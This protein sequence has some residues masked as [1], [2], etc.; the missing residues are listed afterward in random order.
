MRGPAPVPPPPPP[1]SSS[2]T[3]EEVTVD[4]TPAPAF[5]THPDQVNLRDQLTETSFMSETGTMG[6]V[7]LVLDDLLDEVARGHSRGT[8]FT[9]TTTT[10]TVY[11]DEDGEEEQDTDCGDSDGDGDMTVDL[12]EELR[13]QGDDTEEE[14]AALRRGGSPSPSLSG[15]T[16]DEPGVKATVVDDMDMSPSP[17][18]I[19]EAT[20]IDVE[21]GESLGDGGGEDVDADN[22]DALA[23]EEMAD[24]DAGRGVAPATL[25]APVPVPTPPVQEEQQASTTSTSASHPRAPIADREMEGPMDSPVEVSEASPEVEMGMIG[26]ATGVVVAASAA[27]AVMMTASE[28]GE[29]EDEDEDEDEEEEEETNVEMVGEQ[30]GENTDE[31]EAEEEEDEK[32]EEDEEDEEEE[33]YVTPA[34]TMGRH[35]RGEED[36]ETTSSTSA[37]TL[38]RAE[39]LV[40]VM[41]LRESLTALKRRLGRVESEVESRDN[42]VA[43]SSAKKWK[44]KIKDAKAAAAAKPRVAAAAPG[45]PAG[46]HPRVGGRGGGRG[47]GPAE[48]PA[49]RGAGRGRAG[50]ESGIAAAAAAGAAGAGA[51]A[52]A[53]VAER[54]SAPRAVRLYSNDPL[55]H[56]A[57]ASGAGSRAGS[58]AGS[59]RDSRN[60]VRKDEGPRPA[61]KAPVPTRQALGIGAP[62]GGGGGDGGG[63]GST[64]S[65]SP[66]PVPHGHGQGR[67]ILP[68]LEGPGY[69]DDETHREAVHRHKEMQKEYEAARRAERD[70]DEAKI[71][72]LSRWLTEEEQRR[73][74]LAEAA[75]GQRKSLLEKRVWEQ[76][77]ARREEAR[78]RMTLGAGG[79][80]GGSAL[81]GA[82]S[83]GGGAGAGA[84]GGGKYGGNYG[85]SR[86]GGSA[87]RKPGGVG[88]APRSDG[89]R[90]GPTGHSG[91][92]GGGRSRAKSRPRYQIMEEEFE[93]REREI[94]EQRTQRALNERRG[95]IRRPTP[96]Q[97]DHHS[98]ELD[99][100]SP[101][102]V[103]PSPGGAAARQ[104]HKSGYNGHV[105]RL[106]KAHGQPPPEKP[107]L[108][109]PAKVVAPELPTFHSEQTTPSPGAGPGGSMEYAASDAGS[110]VDGGS[111]HPEGSS[112]LAD[113]TGS[114]KGAAARRRDLTVRYGRLVREHF[115]PSVDEKKRLEV[116]Q[117]KDVEVKK[118][119][120]QDLVRNMPHPNHLHANMDPD[121][122]AELVRE[123]RALRPLIVAKDPMIQP[124][125]ITPAPD[126]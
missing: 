90:P 17:T 48:G 56:P 94:E 116:E 35:G 121:D 122:E 125:R 72:Q 95:L 110:V 1:R 81:P 58:R 59:G 83:G 113:V 4:T 8:D 78:R 25:S 63:G 41:T 30:E 9:A 108:L 82:A 49:G 47:R 62:A 67:H 112:P 85:P 6:G 24:Q 88:A 61:R 80:G 10:P 18:I 16:R 101:T 19:E 43:A 33:G 66:G 96:Q 107:H 70:R 2:P 26:A 28:E 38:S 54:S 74:L 97:G 98:E 42:I 106:R 37:P 34:R 87:G 89:G 120:Y 109:T 76:Q 124:K 79:G 36:E 45:D 100:T 51:G 117:R 68:G 20:A 55:M 5:S 104:R 91:R 29:E 92:G 102:S 57:G 84:E 14:D 11:E 73:A 93:A 105:N 111:S 99:P 123:V 44:R 65:G 71:L 31:E 64:L 77:E 3:P 115:L 103:Q 75:V 119:I 21:A 12:P 22:L 69:L 53:V 13:E 40:R 7:D 86:L 27:G 32:D 15:E 39:S 114:G 60:R 118:K 126:R 23:K 50:R 52:G 46:L